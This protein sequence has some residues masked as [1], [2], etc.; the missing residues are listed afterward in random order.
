MAKGP[1]Y[2]V[3]YRRRREKK[4]DYVARRILATSEHPRFVV[5]VSNKTIIVQLTK[6]ELIGDIV[7]AS[8]SSHE[9]NTKFK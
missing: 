4:T 6:S 7:L 5:R 2:R 9:L 1:R 8:S 3:Q